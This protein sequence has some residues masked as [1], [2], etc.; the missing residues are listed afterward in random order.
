MPKR[1]LSPDATVTREKK[2]SKKPK[3]PNM[4]THL[5]TLKFAEDDD[6]NQPLQAS[7]KEEKEKTSNGL[8]GAFFTL[9]PEQ[10]SPIVSSFKAIRNTWN[11]AKGCNERLWVD[12]PGLPG[13]GPP[14]GPPGSGPPT[15]PATQTFY[16][17][18]DQDLQD[19]IQCS[20][21]YYTCSMDLSFRYQTNLR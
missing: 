10:R 2:V 19:C 4:M 9:T 1:K 21:H 3:A 18:Q 11:S 20:Y 8:L 12:S 16:A 6:P 17:D 15:G 7:N 5:R 14:G 13:G